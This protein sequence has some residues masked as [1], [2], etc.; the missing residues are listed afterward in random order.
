MQEYPNVEVKMKTIR[1][2]IV[3]GKKLPKE[4]LFRIARFK[5][6]RIEIS[7][8]GGRGAYICGDE[9]CI[10][11]AFTGERLA[12]S[13]RIKGKIDAETLRRLAE[14]FE[15]IRQCVKK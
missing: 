1:S 13:L 2:C 3:C 7:P 14:E 6:D 10:K 12:R 9:G 5:D 4:Q 11:K 8:I 15:V